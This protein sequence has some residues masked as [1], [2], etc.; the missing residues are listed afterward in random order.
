MPPFSRITLCNGKKTKVRLC[1]SRGVFTK[2]TNTTYIFFY[3]FFTNTPFGFSV[4]FHEY[5]IWLVSSFQNFHSRTL[6]F[7]S[8]NWKRLYYTLRRFY[9]FHECNVTY[10]LDIRSSRNWE[11]WKKH[12][13]IGINIHIRIITTVTVPSYYYS[14]SLDH[15]R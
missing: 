5:N 3:V 15:F 9:V 7:F 12:W 8:T 6:F 1:F 14:P 13:G 10:L 4:V 11:S 2:I